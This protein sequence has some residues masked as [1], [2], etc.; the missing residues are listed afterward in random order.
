MT[1]YSM[2]FICTAADRT[3]ANKMAEALGHG[4]DNVSVPLSTDGTTRTH[5]CGHAIVSEK[6]KNLVEL[7]QGGILPNDVLWEDF[8]LT[9]QEVTDLLGRVII[10]FEDTFER[11]KIRTQ[12]TR[13]RISR[14]LQDV[15]ETRRTR[16]G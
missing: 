8:G 5:Y 4:P 12:V 16:N 13:L 1:Y 9:A 3:K 11:P 2:A 6:F 7:A 14:N 15:T 10:T